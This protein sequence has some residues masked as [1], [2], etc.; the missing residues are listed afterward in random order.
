MSNDAVSNDQSA[1]RPRVVVT[2]AAGLI[3]SLVTRA[4]AERWDVV[5]TDVRVSDGVSALDVADR[6]A[7]LTAFAGADVVVHLGAD[8]SP[9]ADWAH[10]HGPNVVGTY[11]VVSAA[12][13]AGVRRLVLASSLHAVSARAPHAQTRAGDPPRPGNLYGATKAWAEALGAWA[14]ATSP[15]EVVALRIGWVH[16]GRPDFDDPWHDPPAWLSPRD[17]VELVRAAVEGPVDGFTVVCGVSANRLRAAA[18]GDAERRLGYRPVD[19]AWA[20][21]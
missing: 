10:L 5:A 14:A 20:D 4:Q 2:G 15:L 6:A 8:P 17:T 11:A 18:Y 19:D 9:I 21:R 1:A 16:D 12:V 3:G 13:E 7:C